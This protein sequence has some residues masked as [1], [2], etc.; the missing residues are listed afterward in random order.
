[1]A[2]YNA[3]VETSNMLIE[4][5]KQSLTNVEDETDETEEEL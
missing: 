5:M 4:K 1:M 3:H 2:A